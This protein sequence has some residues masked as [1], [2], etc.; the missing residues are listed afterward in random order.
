[1]TVSCDN[2]VPPCPNFHV[3]TPVGTFD[4]LVE[5]YARARYNHPDYAWA[6]LYRWTHSVSWSYT[7]LIEQYGTERTRT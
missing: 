2:T 3:V 1:M 4:Y 7:E 5:R 6:R